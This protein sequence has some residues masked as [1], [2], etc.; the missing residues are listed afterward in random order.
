MYEDRRETFSIKDIFLQLLFII[1]LVFILIWLFPTK[2]YLEKKLDGINAGIDEKLQP[3]YTRLF[4]DNILT[5]KDAAK[6]YFTTPR[7]PQEVGDKVTMTLKEMY[8]KGLLLE[9][10][11][12]NNNACD[13]NKS[14]IEL[15]KT[16]EE[17]QMKVTL[18]CSD[19]EAYVIE[20]LG[21]YDYCN[22]LLCTKEESTQ[23][24]TK[25]GTPARTYTC[26]YVNGQYWGPNGTIVDQTTY[27]QQCNTPTPEPTYSCKY[28][29]GKYWG[30]NA[31]VVDQETYDRECNYTPPTTYTCKYVNG[32]YWGKNSTVVDEATFKKD[33]DIPTPEPV[34]TCKIVDGEYWGA[35]ATKV[36]QATYELQCNS[37]KRYRYQY[38]LQ[39][40]GK[41]SGY[42]AWSEWTTNRIEENSNTKVQTKTEK[43]LD[44]YKQVYGVVDVKYKDEAYYED[45]HYG[46]STRT[47]KRTK[48][49]D[50]TTETTTTVLSYAERTYRTT[51]TYDYIYT[52]KTVGTGSASTSSSSS[53][54][55]WVD[56]GTTSSTHPLS[57][58]STTRYT[59]T[60][61]ETSLAC[62]GCETV[63][64]YYYK[65]EK[66]QGGGG[67]GGSTGT[68]TVTT[69]SC[70]SGTVDMGSG[71]IVST[72][73]TEKYCPTGTDNGSGCV[74]TTTKKFCA[75]GL[76]DTGSG[77]QSISY[78]KQKYCSVNGTDTGSDCVVKVKKTKRV[79]ELIYGYTNGEAVYKNV[80]Y[81]RSAT[82]TC[83]NGSI[84]YQWSESDNDQ[85]L[86]S[87]GYT[88]TGLKEEIK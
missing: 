7:L 64:T 44:H 60:G 71:C 84:D 42:G 68:T 82:R 2:G 88:L 11:D 62:A 63:T 47:V 55:H 28:V 54:G 67:G 32:E 10:V 41:C 86:K 87:K 49:Y 24:R 61:R 20:Y 70:P 12:S 66:Y 46:Y 23:N 73:K 59:E 3:L 79:Q 1:L 57:S 29:G 43:V 80:T 4:T 74:V 30:I 40:G 81:Y 5:M 72:D 65:V 22:G 9:L 6:S 15:T 39:I 48:T 27:I 37:S 69:K 14:Y 8:A 18:S 77:C 38:V 56:A 21:C 35:Y 45:V 31:T 50:Y 52:T 16:E 76:T 85:T 19:K 33:C 75:N 25:D 78:E 26:K 13:P 36:S 83:T 58:T 17:Y 53:S 51:A 34:Y